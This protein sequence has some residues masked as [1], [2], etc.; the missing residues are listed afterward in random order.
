MLF[1]LEKFQTLKE[2]NL[3]EE[4]GAGNFDTEHTTPLGPLL[5]TAHAVPQI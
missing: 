2:E 1:G 4:T 5:F 3:L